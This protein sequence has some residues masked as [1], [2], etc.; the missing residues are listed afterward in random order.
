ML[1]A[2][3]A[4]EA[5]TPIRIVSP[6]FRFCW[7]DLTV[8]SQSHENLLRALIEK[9]PAVLATADHRR[10]AIHCDPPRRHAGRSRH[11]ATRHH[12][13]SRPHLALLSRSTARR[14]TRSRVCSSPR[15]AKVW[16]ASKSPAAFAR[17]PRKALPFDRIAILLRNVEQYQ[18]LVEEA[19]RRAAIP[20]YFSRGA[21]RPDPAGRAFLALLACAG[22]GCSAS[23]FAEY[24]SLGQLP[25]VDQ[26]GAPIKPARNGFRRTTKSSRTSRAPRPR[27]RLRTG[28]S[29]RRNHAG[30]PHRL[31]KTA[32]GRRRHRRPRSLGAP[33]ART[34]RRTA[35]PAPRSRQRRP[36]ASP[37][38][39][40]PHRA[41]RA[42]GT[43]RASLI[44]MLGSLPKAA[45]WGEWLDRL[46][47]AGPDGF[48]HPESV[49]AVLSELEPMS[50][51]GPAALDEVYDVLSEKLGSLRT[52]PP[53][54]RY[55]HVFVGSIDEAR[56]RTFDVVFLPGLAEGLFP[57]RALEDPL[58]LDEHRDEAVQHRALDTQDQRVARERMLLR[59]AAAAA[60]QTLGR[61]LSAHGCHAGPPARAFVLCAR[62]CARRRRPPPVAARIS[63]NAPPPALPRAWIGPRP[64]IPP[65]PSTTP[66]TI[67]LRCRPRSSFRAAS[68]KGSARYLMEVER[69]PGAIAAHARPPLAQSLVRR[70]RHRGS[71]SRHARGSC[72]RTASPS[73]AIR[74]PHCSI[75]RP[76]PTAS[77]CRPSFNSARARRPRR[78]NKWIRSRAARSS[79]PCSS[80]CF[81]S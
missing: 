4:E 14:A 67:W 18:P 47:R 80:S 45:H 20:G 16:S 23:R 38:H 39:R 35:S 73:A 36:I 63:R 17:S 81:A 42:S 58:L 33:P 21:A 3:R 72:K 43:F 25:P 44:D 26:N 62:S 50:E 24:L 75:S 79:T 48:A 74:H 46:I 30:R 7:P 19:L 70:R 76:A 8:E 71:R 2:L 6:D 28:R 57:R 59:S 54:R 15:P 29:R 40:A 9:S 64:P 32:G 51:V 12:T 65:S 77:C 10:R 5:S 61:L 68:A 56:G 55:G 66:S 1:L 53:R 41:A 49:L 34:P 78:W 13:R 11:S 31:G 69:Q 60:A 37:A 22:D 27:L 52:D